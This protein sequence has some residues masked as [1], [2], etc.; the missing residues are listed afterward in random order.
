MKQKMKK[1]AMAVSLTF[2]VGM[3]QAQDV[4]IYGIM[5]VGVVNATN[6]G[7]VGKN[8]TQVLS[9]PT[10]ASRIGF[11]AS[12]NLGSG[13]TVGINLEAQVNPATGD[14]G[15]NASTG[16][17]NTFMSR[18]SNIYFENSQLGMVKA[19][20][21]GNLVSETFNYGDVNGGRNF[22]SSFNYFAD[23]SSF[24]GTSTAKTGIGTFTGGSQVSNAVRLNSPVVKGFKGSIQYT[25]GGVS[26]DA[27]LGALN[28]S[29][30]HTY[31]LSYN[32][33]PLAGA[34]SYQTS[35]SSA[36]L[37]TAQT[38]TVGG[39]YIINKFKVAAGWA[40][41]QNP[42]GAGAANT[43]FDLHQVS[44]KYNATPKI[45]V[46]VGYY[47][48]KDN[49]SSANGSQTWSLFGDYNFTKR[50]GAYAGVAITTNKGGSG[51]APYGGGG[52]NSNSLASVTYPSLIASTGSTQNAFVV[53]MTHRF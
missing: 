38:T 46:S 20:R 5:D 8:A 15:F 30:R 17:A 39:S 36:G 47:N 4:K 10:T 19:G 25:F 14:Q 42:N 7:S 9:N 21:Q 18:Q 2:A 43:D 16:A 12:E 41:F 28:A 48:L 26:S 52:A 23:S 37:T 53:G 32:N 6:V 45:D 31:A 51:F 44:A 33:G 24:G 27:T 40:N 11:L 22:G 35:D 34:I 1:L 29:S 13:T 50:T 49:I 3:A